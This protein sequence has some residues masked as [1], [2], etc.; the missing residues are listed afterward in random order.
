MPL[1]RVVRRLVLVALAAGALSLGWSA[2]VLMSVRA[3]LEDARATLDTLGQ[4]R[5][6]AS[7]KG[8]V[9][10][11]RDDLARA[12]SRL[13]QPGPVLVAEIPLVGRTV[14]AVER[15]AQAGLAVV[16]GTSDVLAAAG[17]GG[18]VDAGEVD[19]AA[20]GRVE[21]ALSRAAS[22][23]AAP[24]AALSAQPLAA[25]PGP[26]RGPVELAQRRLSS[27]P[28]TFDRAAAALRGVSGVL[29]A[30]GQ[31]SLLVVLQNNA[32][33]RGSGGLVTVFAQAT[34]SG[35]Q[36]R[37]GP[38]QDVDAVAAAPA[39]AVRVAAPED[40]RQL[41]GPFLADTTLWKNTNMTPDVPTASAVL[42]GVAERSLG[43]RPDAVLWFDVR[44][45]AT[46]LEGTGPVRLPDGSQ[47]DAANAVD[48]LLSQAYRDAP[49]TP[50]GQAQRRAG[51]RAA[52][53]AVLGRLLGGTGQRPP[54]V[55]LGP[56]LA[57]AAGGRHLAVW[58]ERPQE[59]QDLSR[60][61]LAAGMVAGGGDLSSVA[62]QNLGGGDR[63][64]NKLDYYARRSVTVRA[65]LSDREA[66]V[67][68]D[69]VLRNTAP[70]GGLPVYVSGRVSPGTT[71]NLVAL[72]V[73][74]TATEVVV[75]RGDQVLAV[76]PRPEGDHALIM[77][78][79]S[80]PAGTQASW[81]LSYRLPLPAGRYDLTVVPQP[82]AVDAALDVELRPAAGSSLS[83]PA[84]SDRALTG[85][86]LQATGTFA[87]Q[88]RLSVQVSRA[89]LLSRAMTALRRFW[90][91]P[92][93]LP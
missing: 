42:A 41:W 40:Y 59:Q 80:L 11:A 15:T 68:Q 90:T 33:L 20:L 89:G 64:G 26:V 58:S 8:S 5:D 13:H 83:L 92:V 93:R 17:N 12:V 57:R 9:D 19:L 72:A 3:D 52:A 91:E 85:G 61:G 55:S 66:R 77:D 37:V 79:V 50:E 71:N 60:A 32:E 46:V 87:T 35:G 25:V 51:L 67:Q 23:T 36:V 24:V 82:L 16:T 18:F 56:A 28:A 6:T 14:S 39:D 48:R 53:D 34:A 78:L 70:A 30:S 29:G 63:E 73:P 54:L 27:A 74:R 45:I 88:S 65:V 4:A 62:V 43:R 2:A 86:A 21:R 84:G 1:T 49:D 44:A 81:R 76:S 69:V 31:R 75:T 10:R 7:A 22:S 47:L 38:F